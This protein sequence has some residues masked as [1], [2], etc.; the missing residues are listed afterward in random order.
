MARN[1]VGDAQVR[2][3]IEELHAEGG[4]VTI[5]GIRERL[6]TG[7][8][9]TISRILFNWRE[10]Q[11]SV[12]QP[13]VPEPPDVVSAL[14]SRLWDEAYSAAES[15][16]DAE[17]QAFA[18]QQ[19]QFRRTEKE[20]LDAISTLENKAQ[21][22]E[23]ANSTLSHEL[24]QTL[25]GLKAANI[26]LDSLRDDLNRTAAAKEKLHQERDDALKQAASDAAIV[27]AAQKSASKL[28]AQLERAQKEHKEFSEQMESWIERATKAET[29]C[30]SL[31]QT[32]AA[33]EKL[34]QEL[35]DA[36]KRAASEAANVAALQESASKLEAQ[37]EREQKEHK[38]LSKRLESW[39][40]RATKA[41]TKLKD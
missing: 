36:V 4:A 18:Q 41:E 29:K 13:L 30:D 25:D 24:A 2:E 1:G 8:Y 20:L 7:S 12:K 16:H 15:Q 5:T 35:D 3:V 23:S 9:G 22:L 26:K 34:K 27:A 6:G 10:E 19:A 39:I 40:E 11:K 37:L 31:A 21:Q 14:M 17:R 32:V 33:H 28:E 38:E